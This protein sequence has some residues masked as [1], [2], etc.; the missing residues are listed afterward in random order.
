MSKRKINELSNEDN[1]IKL[2]EQEI[3]FL[4][5]ELDK[6]N[7]EN[8]LLKRK[9]ISLEDNFKV[10]WTSALFGIRKVIE[11]NKNNFENKN[12]NFD[13]ENFEI[14][15]IPPEKFCYDSPS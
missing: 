15:L 1:R 13:S 2:L 8:Q 3:E 11:N 4:R 5:F 14:N 9:M 6:K 10:S 12:D 7:K